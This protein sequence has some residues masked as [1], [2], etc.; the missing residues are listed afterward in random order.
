MPSKFLVEQATLLKTTEDP[1]IVLQNLRDKYTRLS[2]PSQMSRVKDIWFEF[3]CR[4]SEYKECLERGFQSLKKQG[5]SRRFLEQYQTF[6]KDGMKEQMRK[7]KLAKFNQLTGSSR[8]DTIISDIPILPEYMKDYHLT[9]EDKVS[10]SQIS[11]ELLEKRSMDCVEIE[12]TNALIKKCQH[13]VKH[14][15]EDIFI[16]IAAISVIC[17]RRSIEILKLGEFEPCPERG[18]FSCKF[19]GQAKKRNASVEVKNEFICIPLLTKYEYFARCLRFIRAN[20][21]ITGLTNSDVNS[22]YS[23]KLGDGAK[24][25]IGSL[26]VR[27]HDCRVIYGNVTHVAFRNTWSINA[28]LKN[29]LGH[30]TLETSI[31]YS[32]CRLS[33]INLVLGEWN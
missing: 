11:S 14:M 19:R 26:K 13:I 29:I 6:A 22:K 25:L 28:W 23:H 5:I 1:F 18:I 10:T 30:N 16:V 4:H 8:T 24:I 7:S 3:N 21:D 33:K 12:D 2:Y 32:R 27:Q 15:D 31:H 9:V 20:V 17:G